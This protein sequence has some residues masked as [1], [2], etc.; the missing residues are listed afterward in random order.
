MALLSSGECLLDVW[1]EVGVAPSFRPS[2]DL[3]LLH[4]TRRR[5]PLF[6]ENSAD[7]S[8]RDVSLQTANNGR[9]PLRVR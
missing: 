4:L 1:A 3:M 7:L 9:D 5:V 2:I 8:P 6:V